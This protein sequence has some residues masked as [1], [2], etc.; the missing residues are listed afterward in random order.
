MTQQYTGQENLRQDNSPD[1]GRNIPDR[2]QRDQFILANM[3]L[4]H[5]LAHRLKGRGIE[6]EELVSAGCVGL[7]KAADGFEPERGLKF[8]TYAVPVILGEMKRMFRDGGTVKVS[9]SL[10]ELSLRVLREK[11]RLSVQLG[12]EP[13]LEELAD[14]LQIDVALCGEALS[15][16]LPAISLT[17]DHD[18]DEGAQIDLPVQS[19]EDLLTDRLTLQQLLGELEP[20]DRKLIILRY[21]REKTQVETAA[22]LGMTQ[23]QV[24]RREKKAAAADAGKNGLGFITAPLF[25]MKPGQFLSVARQNKNPQNVLWTFCGKT[26]GKII[27]CRSILQAGQRMLCRDEPR[28]EPSHVRCHGLHPGSELLHV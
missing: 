21:F 9:R 5:A 23:V 24:S 2:A 20:K 27:C 7:L 18:D 22:L 19:P 14:S 12:R 25:L 28:H 10:K 26:V 8:S 3:G 4:V 13:R 15:V 17:A 11:E 1:S 6:Y 16:S